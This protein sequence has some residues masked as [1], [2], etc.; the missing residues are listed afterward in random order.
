MNR[1]LAIIQLSA[2]TKIPGALRII[3]NEIRPELRYDTENP[4]SP[5]R[6][7]ILSNSPDIL[8]SPAAFVVHNVV[9]MRGPD[10]H[11]LYRAHSGEGDYCEGRP[12]ALL[13]RL[14]EWQ[15]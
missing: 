12:E 1:E 8:K 7:D 2:L 15:W 5:I 9:Q 14:Q 10:H 3:T 6:S 4:N 13:R 11:G